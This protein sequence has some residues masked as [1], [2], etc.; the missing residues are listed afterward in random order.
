[1]ETEAQ[2]EAPWKCRQKERKVSFLL[3][4]STFHCWQTK[5]KRKQVLANR[6]GHLD[7]EHKICT[8]VCKQVFCSENLT[9]VSVILSSASVVASASVFN[10]HDVRTALR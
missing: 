7:S 6:R 8:T 1:M 10:K 4:F 9:S 2:T 5:Q 3:L